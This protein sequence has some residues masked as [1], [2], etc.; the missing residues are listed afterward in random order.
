MQPLRD[1]S[2]VAADALWRAILDLRAAVGLKARKDPTIEQRF[3]AVLDAL[4]NVAAAPAPPP[5]KA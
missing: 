5:T 4:K 2:L 1:A 3:V